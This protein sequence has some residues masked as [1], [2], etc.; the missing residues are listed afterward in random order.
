MGGRKV[1]DFGGNMIELIN[2]HFYD[3]FMELC[4]NSNKSI[5]L[6]A[7]FVKKDIMEDIL[8][9]K[10]NATNIK[11][12]TNINLQ[13]FHRKASDISAIKQALDNNVGVYNCTTLHAKI[14]IFDNKTCLVTSANLT[15]SGLKKNLECGI[16][17]D[18]INIIKSINEIYK[19]IIN[20]ESVGKLSYKSVED[21]VDILERIPLTPKIK[22]PK[23]DL[24]S[25]E[26]I[27][28]ENTNIIS[29]RLNGWKKEVFLALNKFD[30]NMFNSSM[31]ATIAEQLHEKYPNNKNREAKIR[32]TLQYLRDLGLIEFT[33]PGI[34]KKLWI[35]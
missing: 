11:L 25:S 19:N 5:K 21:I 27:Y 34:Y 7:P 35:N 8:N 12:I 1:T 24:S 2:T 16:L 4:K 30:E 33:S 13:S 10:K 14:Y 15:F 20:N 3:N 31:V 32:Q 28:S 22:Y 9:F 23:I 6:C 26:Q 29:D 17:T 18:E